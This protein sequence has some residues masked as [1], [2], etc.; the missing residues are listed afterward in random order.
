MRKWIITTATLKK[1]GVQN[2][3]VAEQRRRLL[4]GIDPG[5]TVGYAILDT[6]GTILD[7]GAHK[8]FSLDALITKVI[9]FGTVLLVGCDK[10]KVPDFVAAFATKVGAKVIYPDAD[11]LVDEKRKLTEHLVTHPN[12]E[13]DALAAA[14][15]AW[16][17]VEPLFKK[18]DA[19]LAKHKKETFADDV[20]G[21]VIKKQLSVVAAL[22]FIEAEKQ[23]QNTPPQPKK[24]LPK[25]SPPTKQTSN[26][27][28]DVLRLKN[29]KKELLSELLHLRKTTRFLGKRIKK[30]ETKQNTDQ[31][32]LLKEQRIIALTNLVAEKERKITELR[33]HTTRLYTLL[34]MSKDHVIM[35]HLKNLG[36]QEYC[37][38]SQKFPLKSH[39][40]IFVDDPYSFSQ[41]T[42]DEIRLKNL[43]ILSKQDKKPNPL[44]TIGI[45]VLNI[46]DIPVE[47][48]PTLAVIK[49]TDL[50]RKR[51]EKFWMYDLVQEYHQERQEHLRT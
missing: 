26:K 43:T 3:F 30:L 29:E 10:A 16:K 1:Y 11:L 48:H 46:N 25:Q 50:E 28:Q 4:V 51:R 15:F 36:W 32:L 6:A 14:R 37:H 39:D 35:P 2:I 7:Q 41:Q 21:I 44:T 27:K 9:S 31:R 34:S 49:K 22:R 19:F 5:T 47:T 45:A 17:N 20:K 23:Q 24:S 18:I 12:H 13:L 8:E 40:L 42:I 33:E 38:K